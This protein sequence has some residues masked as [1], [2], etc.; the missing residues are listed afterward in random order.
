MPYLALRFDTEAADAERWCDAL[1]EAGALSVD[2]SDPYAGTP[3]EAAR[4]D[5]P[6]E[7]DAGYWAVSRIEALFA[8]G[9]DA[10]RALNAAAHAMGT[11]TPRHDTRAIDDHDW[12]RAT[13]SQFGPIDLGAGFF[14]VPTW[15][16][17]PPDATI[18]LRLDPGVAFGTGSHP[19]TRLCLEWLRG[20]IRGGERVVDYGCGS[21]I[22]AI[23][24]AKLGAAVV[25]GTDVDAQ[26]LVASRANAK[27]NGVAARFVAPGRLGASPADLL[28]ANILA[29]PLILLA[30]ALASRVRPGGRI[31]LSGIL[32][33]QGA[34]VAAAYEPWFTLAHARR[35]D[36]WVLLAGERRAT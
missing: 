1:L 5:E 4:Y 34:A 19:T 2:V 21:G 25:S 27:A 13:Q 11:P 18:V 8:E 9:V 3:R 10:A 24:A 26:A 35:L 12:V 17:P 14:V 31:A 20:T 16:E 32:E 30:S 22:L 6:G 33:P 28:V 29:N 7:P 36:G 15:C 23:A